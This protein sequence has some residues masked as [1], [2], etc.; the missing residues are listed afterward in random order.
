MGRR[1]GSRAR[2]VSPGT[3][4]RCWGRSEGKGRLEE[5]GGGILEDGVGGKEGGRDTGGGGRGC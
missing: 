1:G 2:Q 5:G 3:R 4:A